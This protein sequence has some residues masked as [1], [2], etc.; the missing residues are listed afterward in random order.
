MIQYSDRSHSQSLECD[1]PFII[2][3]VIA[4]RSSICIDVVVHL[5]QII[6]HVQSMQLTIDWV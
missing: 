2:S 5:H 4:L 3:V 1:R 6:G